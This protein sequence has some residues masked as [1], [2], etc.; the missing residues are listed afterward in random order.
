MICKNFLMPSFL[1]AMRGYKRRQV[2]ELFSRIDGT[3]GRG[4]AADDP[5]TA[6]DVRAARFNV[7]F[8][9]YAPR[10]V[11]DAVSAAVQELE[12]IGQ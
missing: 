9:G 12:R 6:A 3:L 5:V 4:S 2:D 1:I 11:D 8:R 10:D 7:S